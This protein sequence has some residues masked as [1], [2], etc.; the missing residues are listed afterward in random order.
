MWVGMGKGEQEGLIT[1]LTCTKCGWLCG[2]T[3]LS[4]LLKLNYFD[5]LYTVQKYSRNT[6]KINNHGAYI[7]TLLYNAKAQNEADVT[8]QVQHDLYGSKD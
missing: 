5:F 1:S 8:N 6:T 3:S 2:D 7:M 4:V